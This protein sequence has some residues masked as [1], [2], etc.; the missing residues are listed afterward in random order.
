MLFS[1][2]GIDEPGKRTLGAWF[3]DGIARAG[4][5]KSAWRPVSETSPGD[6]GRSRREERPSMPP[7]ARRM[8]PSKCRN[9][10]IEDENERKRSGS[11][12]D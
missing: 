6:V 11:S 5:G 10:A 3:V 1:Y 8:Q 4:L 12:V 9:E 7:G 2:S